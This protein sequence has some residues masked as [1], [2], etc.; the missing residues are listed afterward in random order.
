MLTDMAC[1]Y[2]DTQSCLQMSSGRGRGNGGGS[3]DS[4]ISCSQPQM[5]RYIYDFVPSRKMMELI[6]TNHD[7]GIALRER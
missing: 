3:C 1:L 4:F 7:Q 6:L 5:H 2:Y